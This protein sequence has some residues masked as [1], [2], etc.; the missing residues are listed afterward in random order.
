[1]MGYFVGVCT[2]RGLNVNVSKSKVMLLGGE[3]GLEC[4]DC[5]DNI[6]SEYI[7]LSEFK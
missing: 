4:E 1:M 2:R 6:R 7:S 5:V 3:E